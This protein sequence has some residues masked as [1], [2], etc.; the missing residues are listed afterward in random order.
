MHFGPGF[1]DFSPASVVQMQLSSAPNQNIGFNSCISIGRLV[2][3]LLHLHVTKI[4]TVTPWSFKD[5]F[6]CLRQRDCQQQRWW[7]CSTNPWTAS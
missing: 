7:S 5:F 4:A 6:F 2:Q 3:E 1:A